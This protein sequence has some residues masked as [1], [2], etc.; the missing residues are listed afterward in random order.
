MD[1]FSKV[2]F[3]VY[4][5][6]ALIELLLSIIP[7]W[8]IGSLLSR[9]SEKERLKSYRIA[10]LIY[11]FCD[12]ANLLFASMWIKILF[13]KI[14]ALFILLGVTIYWVIIWRRDRS[15]SWWFVMIFIFLLCLVKVSFSDSI[16]SIVSY[17]AF[18]RNVYQ[19]VIGML[20]GK[21]IF[22]VLTYIAMVG[23]VRYQMVKLMGLML[24]FGYLLW[25]L[26]SDEILSIIPGWHTTLYLP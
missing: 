15:I 21:I 7:A 1:N 5:N 26:L 19:I 4:L 6:I 11:V 14:L 18:S 23:S 3:L 12:I 16:E 24:L 22:G 8:S 2:A 10:F 20:L 25:T 17:V 9:V 13:V